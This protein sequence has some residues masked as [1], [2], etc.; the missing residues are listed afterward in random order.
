MKPFRIDVRVTPLHF[1]IVLLCPKSYWQPA[2]TW[3]SSFGSVAA[4]LKAIQ[5]GGTGQP[6]GQ[7]CTMYFL[8]PRLLNC[9]SA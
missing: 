6:R 7:E 1:E 4:L 5:F 8:N 2:G 9:S 3:N